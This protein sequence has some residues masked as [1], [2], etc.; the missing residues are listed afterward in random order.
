[1]EP[2]VFQEVSYP[3]YFFNY[4]SVC[5]LAKS[6]MHTQFI[7]GGIEANPSSFNSGSE[8][9]Y[10]KDVK[11]WPD[12]NGEGE[13]VIVAALDGNWDVFTDSEKQSL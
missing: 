9:K 11:L 4:N 2:K 5:C 10:G 12:L 3:V 1:M 8:S 7:L 6:R 13:R